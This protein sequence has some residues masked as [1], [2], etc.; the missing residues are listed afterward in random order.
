LN[1]HPKKK[2]YRDPSSFLFK[3][4]NGNIRG[5]VKDA[6]T[7]TAVRDINVTFVH[8]EV[9]RR[10]KANSS[11]SYLFLGVPAGGGTIGAHT[12]GGLMVGLQAVMVS[13]NI[14][15]SA[16]DILLFKRPEPVPTPCP[17]NDCDRDK[18]LPSSTWISPSG[19]QI[20]SPC[21]FCSPCVR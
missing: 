2:G 3:G 16:P 14:S 9:V 8:G 18:T 1:Q 20:F 10:T 15:T 21:A 5:F 7:G 6:D 12:V 17:T 11:G 4:A 13:P 19:G